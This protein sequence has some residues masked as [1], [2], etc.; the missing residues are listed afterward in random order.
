MRGVAHLYPTANGEICKRH[1]LHQSQRVADATRVVHHSAITDIDSM[2]TVAATVHDELSAGGDRCDIWHHL[3]RPGTSRVLASEERCSHS[4][5]LIDS[6]ICSVARGK[7]HRDWSEAC[8]AI[9]RCQL[10]GGAPTVS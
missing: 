9:L 7:R 1:L 2:M 8:Q 3:V 6:S 10:H 5:L 4:P